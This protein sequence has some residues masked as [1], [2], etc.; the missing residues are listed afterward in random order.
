MNNNIPLLSCLKIKKY[1]QEGNNFVKILRNI[2]FSIYPGEIVSIIGN[3]G[4]G[5]S[6]LLHILGGLDDPSDGEIIFEGKSMK[7]LSSSQR[8]LMRNKRLGFIY[9]F[10]YLLSDFNVLENVEIPLII[11][12]INTKESKKIALK[13]LVS[14]GLEKRIYH[15]PSMLSG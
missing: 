9:Q 11:G 6:T 5:K 7:K 4:S 3:S 2:N 1:Y 13:M 15:F 8:A 12:G 10:H 14:V